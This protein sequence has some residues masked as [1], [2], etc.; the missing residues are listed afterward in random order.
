MGAS[1]DVKTLIL[2]LD[3]IPLYNLQTTV[4]P[5]ISKPW[6]YDSIYVIPLYQEVVIYQNLPV[7]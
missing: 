4:L 3:L 2:W 7:R 6:F 1:P 5:P